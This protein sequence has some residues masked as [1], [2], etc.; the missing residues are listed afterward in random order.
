MKL[1]DWK[2]V[3]QDALVRIPEEFSAEASV[4][5]LQKMEVHIIS[6]WRKGLWVKVNL[7]DARIYPICNIDP[8]EALEWEV[9]EKHKKKGKTK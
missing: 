2:G 4:P 7:E 1:K 9:I 6:F 8:K 3:L 5:G